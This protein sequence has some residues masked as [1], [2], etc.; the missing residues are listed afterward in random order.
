MKIN[1]SYPLLLIS[2][3]LLTGCEFFKIKETKPLE[4][5]ERK[6]IARAHDA[7]IYQEDLEGIVPK[8]MSG[9][10]SAYRIKSYIDSWA[11]K[12][13]LIKE[14][15][16]VID[17]DEV[18]IERKILDYRYSLMGYEF[19]SYYINSHLSKEVSAEEIEQYY[20]D[21]VDNFILKQN[22][23]KGKFINLPNE[24][25]KTENISKLIRSNK[26]KDRE[27][28]MSYC[29]SYATTYQLRDSVWMNFD[30]IIISSPLSQ[31]PNKVHFLKSNN[32]VEASD[33]L[34]TYYLNIIEYKITDERS[35]LEFVKEQI[36]DVI[37][38]RRKIELAKKLEEDVYK[39][40][41]A[42]NDV[43]IYND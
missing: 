42:N 36:K 20:H 16:E 35:P 37:I 19:Q 39:K 40:A 30:D 9:E 2:F 41:V 32:Y 22:I 33:S 11:R 10:D 25:P 13:L 27:K 15:S 17:F 21:N 18:D 6:P 5:P 8:G 26:P 7:F 29:L 24:A 28:L 12:Q 1:K 4:N 31:I 38:N 34:N 3:I 43:E 23:I 14:A